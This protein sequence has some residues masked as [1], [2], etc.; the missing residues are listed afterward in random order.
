MLFCSGPSAASL[1]QFVG[2]VV[3]AD[4]ELSKALPLTAYNNATNA[5]AGGGK[6]PGVTRLAGGECMPVFFSVDD[7]AVRREK[8]PLFVCIGTF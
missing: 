1:K 5:I 7:G 3:A 6:A 2:M 4:T 8:T